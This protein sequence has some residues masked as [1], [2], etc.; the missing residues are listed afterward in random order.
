MDP[1][2]QAALGA[3]LPLAV[4]RRRIHLLAAGLCGAVAGMAAD[5]DV[6]IRSSDDPLLFL[7]YHRQF[8]HALVFVPLGALLCALPLQVL[9]RWWG[10]GAAPGFAA[11]WLCCALGYLSHPLIDACTSYGTMLFWPFSEARIALSLV[12]VVDPLFTLPLLLA[13]AAALWRRR[14][15]LALAGLVWAGLYLAAGAVQQQAAK[16]AILQTASARGHA[17]QRL[18]VKPSF[19]N[20]IVWKTIY[21]GADGRFHVDAVRRAPGRAAQVIAGASLPRL[22]LARDV[23]WLDPASRQ[24]AD[25]ARFRRFSEGFIA[26]DPEHG[27]RVID[28]RYSFLPHRL[29]PLWSIELS[30]DAPPE[31]HA[32]Y[33][34]HR[35]EARAR[36][37]DLWRL[38]LGTV[39]APA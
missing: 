31:A 20:L 27:N 19:A 29:A 2:T 14:P 9:F 15:A 24:A 36:L 28:V 33:R 6:L 13:V 39:P 26:R 23:P 35:G 30:P 21:E 25:V 5:L 17:P 38:I 1:L 37:G 11:T 10:R 32:R 16:T 4:R 8:S 22:A 12:S 18:V 7:E 3:A 34:T